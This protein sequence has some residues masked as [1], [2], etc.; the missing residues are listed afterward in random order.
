MENNYHPKSIK[1][2]YKAGI[3]V[4]LTISDWGARAKLKPQDLGFIEVDIPEFIKLGHKELMKKEFLAKIDSVVGRAWTYLYGH[5]FAFPF[6]NARFVP[7]T[8]IDEVIN[9]M[10]QFKMEYKEVVEEFLANYE[11]YRAEMFLEY[12]KAFE[13]IL[14]TNPDNEIDKQDLL[15][16]LRE[17]Y[18][19][20]EKLRKK[21]GFD[22]SIFEIT[23]PNFSA[24]SHD[25]ALTKTF[26]ANEMTALYA[27]KVSEKMD[28]FLEDVTA[29]LK[30]WFL[31]TVSRMKKSMEKGKLTKLQTN[32][33]VRFVENFRK[34]DFIGFDTEIEAKMEEFSKKLEGVEKSELS[35]DE[36]K[37]TLQSD[38]V[39]LENKIVDDN[40]VLGRFKRY[41][42]T[43][44]IKNE[45]S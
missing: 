22:F 43:E 42:E 11:Q 23:T 35:D 24:L 15:R 36:F 29:R 38:L 26:E 17:K 44:E 9:Q 16:A 40:V 33:F 20:I 37:K 30:G 14:K 4:D 45:I 34:M 2:I 39:E 7:V 25:E 41:I 13:E 21:F 31:S 3:V 28:L 5:S 10:E 27:K 32:A 1:N 19:T 12:D 6:G 8:L 18:P